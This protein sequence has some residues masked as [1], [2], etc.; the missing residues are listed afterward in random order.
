MWDLEIALLA[1]AVVAGGAVA[2]PPPSAWGRRVLRGGWLAW[3]GAGS[4]VGADGR[5]AGAVG[6][7]RGSLVVRG[8]PR[9]CTIGRGWRC[10]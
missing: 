9:A 6:V 8:A 3:G 5:G 1:T 4:Y 7:V 10:G 2:L